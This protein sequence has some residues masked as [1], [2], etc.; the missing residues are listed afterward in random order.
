MGSKPLAF[1]MPVY[2]IATYGPDGTPNAMNAAWGGISG[3]NRITICVDRSHKTVA[4][5]EAHRAFTVSFATEDTEV[6]CDY[7]GIVSGNMVPNKFEIAGF[8]AEKSAHV[9]A[10]IIKELPL[11]LECRMISYDNDTEILVGEIVNAVADES[12]LTDGKV[13]VTKLK[14]IVYDTSGHAYYGLGKKAGSA[15]SDGKKLM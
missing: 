7:V 11:A 2:I 6:P 14:P 8:H 12:I 1:P 5:L 3:E 15:F 9:D 10:P 4:N 13:D